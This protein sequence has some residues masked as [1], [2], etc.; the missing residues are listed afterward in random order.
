M[1]PKQVQSTGVFRVFF[2]ALILITLFLIILHPNLRAA[3]DDSGTALQFDGTTD[4]VQ[5]PETSTVFAAGWQNTKTIELWVRPAVSGPSCTTVD[6]CPLIFGDQP[7]WWGISIGVVGGL[8]RIWVWNFTSTGL[9]Q[10]GISYTPGLWTHIAMVHTSGTLYAYQD[11]S[12]AGSVSSGTT[13]Q[14]NTGA[15]PQLRIGGMIKD[16][17]PW[18]FNG[19]IDEVRLWNT[20]RNQ[21]DIE[22]DLGR[23]LAGNETDLRAYYKMSNGSGLALTDDSVHTFNGTLRDGYQQVPGDGDFPLWVTSTAF[24]NPDAPDAINDNYLN[25]SEDMPLVVAAPGVLSNDSD[26]NLL[27]LQAVLPYGPSQGSLTLNTNGSFTYNPPLNFSGAVTFTYSAYNGT[28]YS[29]PALVTLNIN[30]VNDAP[31]ITEGTTENVTMDED[32]SPTPFSLTLH[33]VDIENDPITWSLIDPPASGSANAAG[34]G[35]SQVVSYTPDPNVYGTDSFVVRASDGTDS[36]DIT[37]NVTINQI[38]DDPV[39]DQGTELNPTIDEDSGANIFPLTASD[40]DPDLLT[41]R[42]STPPSHGQAQVDASGVSV[43]AMYTP[44]LNYYGPDSFEVEVDDG[45]GGLDTIT[46]NLTVASQPDPPIVSAGADQSII[47]GQQASFS[48]SFTDADE[49]GTPGDG[50]LLNWDFEDGST[51]NGTLTPSHRYTDDGIY[52]VQLSVTDPQSNTGRGSLQVTVQNAAPVLSSP[53]DQQTKAYQQLEISFQFS[54]P[55]LSDTHSATI[56]W[57]NGTQSTAVVNQ[58]TRTAEAST[59]YKRAGE[60]E[61]AINLVDDDG[62]SDTIHFMVIVEPVYLNFMPVLNGPVS[63]P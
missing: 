26:P 22:R 61:A 19:Q 13:L 47:E 12:L 62:G 39:I 1:K 20:A 50:Y 41:W 63:G 38:N 49:N 40:P 35:T 25:G 56:D 17:I 16:A 29:T 58:P 33:A 54:D 48:G 53:G 45:H 52:T 43:S 59:M 60:Y 51:A 21:A 37:V 10:V 15:Q 57:G 30:P 3:A 44:G 7:R 2:N 32:S 34:T 9:N 4:W 36:S 5:L 8:D 31:E 6:Q 46:I 11:G 28:D 18:I 14:P 27:T 23:E 55:G 42:I 24:N